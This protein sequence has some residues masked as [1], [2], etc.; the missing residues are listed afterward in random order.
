MIRLIWFCFFLFFCPLSNVF[1]I[2]LIPVTR[3]F[4]ITHE[5]NQPSEVS[6]SPKGQV[7]VLDGVNNKIKI[8][9]KNGK[10]ISSF[11]RQG[12]NNG[13]FSFPLGIDI[14]EKGRIYVAD[15]GNHRIQAFNSK[16]IYLFQIKI[17]SGTT[18][19][20]DPTDVA[21]DL[22]R[23]RCYVVDNDNHQ[24]LSYNLLNQNLL[25][26]FGRPGTG[27]REFRY[28]F[29]ISLD[30]QSYIYI[31]DVVN[32][33][34][35]V[36]NPDGLFVNYIGGWGV[37]KGQFFRPKG[38]A[39]DD[40]DQVY[41]SDSYMGVIQVFESTGEFKA[42]VGDQITGTIKKFMTPVGLFV[43]RTKRLYVVEMSANRVS[44][45]QMH[46]SPADKIL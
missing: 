26:T 5:L 3:L 24:F 33:R 36:F 22:K 43:D 13:E 30:T 29:L 44:V 6:V 32:T 4:D 45:F 15:S 18:K 28:P 12:K 23:N 21:V 14:D 19:P 20:A 7:Y 9:D 1:G 41:I 11:G 35:Q 37:K 16:G 38:I 42:A 31:V 10:F 25:K 2:D 8:F 34:I 39:I 27:K 17:K 46:E 40:A